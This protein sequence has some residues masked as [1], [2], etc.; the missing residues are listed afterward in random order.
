MLSEI[1]SI[2]SPD[3]LDFNTF[4]PTDEQSFSFLITA[5][6]GPRGELVEESFDVHVCTPKWLM[7][8]YNEYD[9]ILGRNKLIVFKFDMQQILTRIKK[10]FDNCSGEDWSEIAIKLSR[11]GHWEFEDYQKYKGE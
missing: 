8:N 4:W 3:I 1:K 6:V 7:D 11:I 5:I 2:I 9:I 10:L